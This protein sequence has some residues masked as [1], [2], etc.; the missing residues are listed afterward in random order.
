MDKTILKK[1]AIESRIDLMDKIRR[2]INL[3]YVDEQFNKET[4]GDIVVLSND[5]RTITLTKE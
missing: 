4:K 5:K 3:L 1:F 2:K